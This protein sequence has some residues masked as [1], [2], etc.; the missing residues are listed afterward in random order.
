MI[1]KIWE[2]KN[3]EIQATEKQLSY[4]H[5]L[6]F[7]Q[8]LQNGEKL[9][10]YWEEDGIESS[11]KKLK[12]SNGSQFKCRCKCEVNNSKTAHFDCLLI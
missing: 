10:L 11:K 1:L 6:K 12:T 5:E 3:N 9:L 4:P 7:S 2:I 8:W